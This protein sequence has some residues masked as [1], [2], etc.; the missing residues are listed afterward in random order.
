[1]DYYDAIRK[2][3]RKFHIILYENLVNNQMIINTFFMSE[4]LKPRPIKIILLVLQIDLYLFVN[5]LFFDEEYISKKYHVKKDL[6]DVIRKI[7]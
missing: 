5:A 4:P 3:K 7:H 6:F 2:D 1:M